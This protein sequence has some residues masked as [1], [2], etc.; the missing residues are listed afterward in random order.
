MSA[1]IQF[2]KQI[3]ESIVADHYYAQFDADNTNNV[4]LVP[5]Y[6]PS[7]AEVYVSA[8]F[9]HFTTSGL[10]AL[11]CNTR[12]DIGVG[13]TSSF[14]AG[15]ESRWFWQARSFQTVANTEIYVGICDS[16][17]GSLA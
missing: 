8:A 4:T 12:T 1:P 9:I 15:L 17:G 2:F 7:G 13:T 11:Q 5:T 10:P 14:A 6:M 3:N 16:S